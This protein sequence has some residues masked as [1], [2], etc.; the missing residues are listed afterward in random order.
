MLLLTK[1]YLTSLVKFLLVLFATSTYCNVSAK[2]MD[3]EYEFLGIHLGI[4]K[5]ELNKITCANKS[6]LLY[7]ADDMVINGRL[8]YDSTDSEYKYIRVSKLFMN[9]DSIEDII[10]EFVNDTLFSIKAIMFNAANINDSLLNVFTT[11]YGKTPIQR[12]LFYNEWDE[13]HSVWFNSNEYMTLQTSSHPLQH[14]FQ[15]SNIRTELKA[16]RIKS[17]EDMKAYILNDSVYSES[18]NIFDNEDKD[19]HLLRHIRG[20]ELNGN[21]DDLVVQV[22]NVSNP[23]LPQYQ[24]KTSVRDSLFIPVDLFKY[25]IDNTNGS[26]QTIEIAIK[27]S[28]RTYLKETFRFII[29]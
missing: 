29:D 7:N 21:S 9:Q 4:S 2:E 10:F 3:S 15:L 23:I 12:S 6:L 1:T 14:S 19:I 5:D 13:G 18:Y 11:K 20:I 17:I 22:S 16:S 8:K 24:L 27:H 28:N 25:I 26:V